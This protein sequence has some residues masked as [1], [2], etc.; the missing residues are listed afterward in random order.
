MDI[1]FSRHA[2]RR[3]K[4]YNVSETNVAEILKN[5]KLIQGHQSVIGRISGFEL[6]IK[7]VIDVDNDKVV[8]VTAYPLKKTRKK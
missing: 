8:V 4:L 7:T 2:Q 3:L 1:H 6:P 5:S